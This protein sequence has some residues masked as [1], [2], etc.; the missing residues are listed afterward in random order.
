MSHTTV[1]QWLNILEASYLI[2]FL[3]LFHQSFNKRLIKIPMLYFH[4]TG[5]A[6]ILLGLEKEIQLETHYPKG[7]L[8]ENLIVLEI[9]KRRLNQ[10]LPPNLYLGL[11]ERN[12]R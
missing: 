4:D 12:I 7:A 6:C 2:F 11:I 3:Q 8:F 9:F 10:G 1:R 5:L